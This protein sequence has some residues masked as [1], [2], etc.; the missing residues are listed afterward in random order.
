MHK[1]LA[2][3]CAAC[4]ARRRNVALSVCA[5]QGIEDTCFSS[6][7]KWALIHG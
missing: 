6:F 5:A 1:Y 2:L 3:A 4:P 7:W